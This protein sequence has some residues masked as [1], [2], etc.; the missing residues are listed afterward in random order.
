V[1]DKDFL[2]IEDR[3]AIVIPY[4]MRVENTL[5]TARRI[6]HNEQDLLVLPLRVSETKVLR[7]LAYPIPNPL[8]CYDWEGDKPFDTQR[9]TAEMLVMNQRAYV[10]NDLGTGKTRAALHAANFLMRMGELGRALIVAPLSTLSN[11]W[12]RELFAHFPDRRAIVVHGDRRKR[13]QLLDE[14]ADFYIINHDG[15][16]I[17]KEAL[18]DR[19]DINLI[20]VDEIATFRNARTRRWKALNQVINMQRRPWAW[21]MTGSPT[22]NEPPDAW[23]QC[24]LLT[25]ASVPRRAKQFKEQTMFQ[26]SKFKWIARKEAK[27]IVHKAMQPAVRYTR[28]ETTEIPPRSYYYLPVP[29]A[30]DQAAH[31]KQMEKKYYLQFKEGEV[32]AA[33]EGVKI[34]KLLQLASGFLYTT[35]Q[36]VV[37]LGGKERLQALR[38]LIESTDRKV[39]VFVPFKPLVHTV[40]AAVQKYASCEFVYGDVS[41]KKRDRIFGLFQRSK[42]PHVI[43]AHPKCMAHGLTLTKADTIV[44][45]SP[46]QSPEIY[47]QANGRITRAGQ[48]HKQFVYHIVGTK[49]EAS[50]Y[51]RLQQKQKTQGALLDLFEG[52]VDSVWGVA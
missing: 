16:H 42:H 37:D 28:E 10:L 51:K 30:P 44:W 41:K 24:R 36:K 15:V 47:E 34:N 18:A 19:H 22:P 8:I 21:G 23:A 14:E 20:I 11:V 39:L 31:Y 2:V 25:P 12:D 33:N 48:V 5:P 49:L 29:L 27:E 26:V 38:D 6:Q 52:S 50:V 9:K 46:H 43:V 7:N 17:I 40:Y 4:D 3:K 1:A 35:E 45:F 13:F 32:T